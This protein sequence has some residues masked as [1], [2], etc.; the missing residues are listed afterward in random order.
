MWELFDQEFSKE[1]V[2][3]DKDKCTICSSMMRV[4]EDGFLTCTNKKCGLVHLNAIDLS[5]E[6]RFYGE[7]MFRPIQ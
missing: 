3:I 6:W 5:A 7:D 2:S 4:S 1:P